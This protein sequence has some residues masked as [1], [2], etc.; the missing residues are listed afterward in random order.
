MMGDIIKI[1]GVTRHGKNR[2]HEHGEMWEVTQWKSELRPGQQS[3]RSLKTGEERW[4]DSDNFEVILPSR[5]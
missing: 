4:L 5:F 2:V 1:Q 3:I